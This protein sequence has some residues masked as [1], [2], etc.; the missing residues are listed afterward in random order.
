LSHLPAYR[1][2]RVVNE[3]LFRWEAETIVHLPEGVGTL[4]FLLP[5]SAALMEGT[6]TL[7]R[8]HRLVLWRKHGVMARSDFSVTR[9]A[10]LI[11]YIETAARYEYMDV[12][13][14]GKGEG[15]SRDE[16]RAV[17]DAFHVQTTLL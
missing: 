15:L 16:L 17:V 9:A 6:V 3:R 14:G 8:A 2:Q 11:E 7:L 10:D 13:T 4:P 12:V 5:G 1:E